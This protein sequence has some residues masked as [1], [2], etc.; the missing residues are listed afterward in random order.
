MS[1]ACWVRD[2]AGWGSAMPAGATR[3]ARASH[4]AEPREARADFVARRRLQGPW[5]AGNQIEFCI[6]VRGVS[7]PLLRCG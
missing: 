3:P 7:G 6:S 5:P 1:L 4:R 2:I